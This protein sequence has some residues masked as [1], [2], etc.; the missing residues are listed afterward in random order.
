MSGVWS[1]TFLAPAPLRNT[2]FWVR[3]GFCGQHFQISSENRTLWE[4]R[5]L[6][7]WCADGYTVNCGAHSVG[8]A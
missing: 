5:H 8:H 7:P 6:G 4:G 2:R 1:L 3:N